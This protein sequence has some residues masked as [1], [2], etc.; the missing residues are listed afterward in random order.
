[1]LYFVHFCEEKKYVF[2][3]LRKF[4]VRISQKDWVSKSQICKCHIGGRSANRT[5]YFTSMVDE[6][7]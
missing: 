5:N 7:T 2:A 3:D 1:M 6:L 4:E